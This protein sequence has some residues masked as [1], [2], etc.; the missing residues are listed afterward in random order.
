[1]TSGVVDTTLIADATLKPDKAQSTKAFLAKYRTHLPE[2]AL[3]EFC[4]GPLGYY[5]W[6]HNKFVETRSFSRTLAA[7]GKLARA[8]PNRVATSLEAVAR[9]TSKLSKDFASLPKLDNG[10][11][12]DEFQAEYHRQAASNLVQL[13]WR[14]RRRLTDSV[15]HELDCFID[16]G[17]KLERSL[18]TIDSRCDRKA[19][20]AAAE[21]L[22]ARRDRLEKVLAA[23]KSITPQRPEHQRRH[24]ALR[25]LVRGSQ[26]DNQ[27]CRSLG[28][29]VF[30]VLAEPATVVLTTNRR[31][32]EPLAAALGLTVDEP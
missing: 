7:L 19:K 23:N 16:R 24:K 14:K 3:R 8:Q 5:K 29:A 4:A 17:P 2:Y 1:V 13:A 10:V 28:D 12:L 27:L 9:S 15:S 11:S 32:H 21:Q 22:V 30:S 20:C 18:L 31:D 25:A 26:W 6:L